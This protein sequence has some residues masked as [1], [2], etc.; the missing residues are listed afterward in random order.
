MLYLINL[1]IQEQ[2]PSCSYQPPELAD[3]IR[4]IPTFAMTPR[5]FPNQSNFRDVPHFITTFFKFQQLST[6]PHN[7]NLDNTRTCHTQTPSHLDPVSLIA[8]T[9]LPLVNGFGEPTTGISPNASHVA[10]YLSP[11]HFANMLF[12]L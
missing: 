12:S 10:R 8:F 1:Y 3:I 9:C 4:N 2:P 7:A 6:R 11:K 5:L